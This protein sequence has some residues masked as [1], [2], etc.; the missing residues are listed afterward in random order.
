MSDTFTIHDYALDGKGFSLPSI[1]IL[2]T[3]KPLSIKEI[4]EIVIELQVAK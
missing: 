2:A 1:N 4:E 3:C